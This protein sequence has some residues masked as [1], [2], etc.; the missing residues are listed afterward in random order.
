MRRRIT[1]LA[2][3]AV[4]GAAAAASAENWPMWGRTPDRNM[5]SH[6]KGIPAD[7]APGRFVQG[8]EKV[9]MTTTRHVKWVA[10]LG[11]QTHGN[12]TVAGGRVFVGTN[13]GSP[14]N[15]KMTGDRSIV[16]CFD[17]RTGELLWQL[18]VPKLGAGKVSDWEYLGICSSPAIDGERAYVVTTRGELV[19]LDVQGMAD[20][21]Q[22][23][24]DEATYATGGKGKLPIGEKDADIIWI[25]DVRSDL[26]VFP[27]NTSSNSPLVI[28]DV[29]Y[30][31]T[32]NGVDWSHK[33]LPSPAAPAMVG[34]NKKTGEL[35]GEEA[36]GISKRTLH[37]N[38]SS[39]AMGEIG[40]RMQLVFGGGDGW[41]Y[42]FDPKPVEDEDGFLIFPAL[43]RYNLNPPEYFQRDGRKIPYAHRLGP[44]EVI[45]TPVIHEGKVYIGTGQDPEHGNGVAN[46]A[47]ID[48]AGKKGDITE[49]GRVWEHRIGR[50][51]STASVV[52]DL[53]YVAEYAGYLNCLDAK[54][55]K[56]YWQHDLRSHIWSSTL[57]ADG[58][59]FV[60]DED[61]V[62]SIFAQGKEKKLINRVPFPSPIHTSP[63]VANGVLYIGSQT[64][65]YAIAVESKSDKTA[66]VESRK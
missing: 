45:A 42:G 53:V 19:C 9:D 3:L 48:P 58:K 63:I 14:R 33:N 52:G 51:M 57:A 27:H 26:D 28:G 66:A 6:E 56:L 41:V 47:C 29:V 44:S 21:N 62:L 5:V 18:A 64:H 17:E 31:G 38:W 4:I 43:W 20:G 40:G 34:V 50:T 15:P 49:S 1:L 8:A 39:P 25:Y 32:S 30:I 35:V 22:G 55:G 46:F 61:G 12:M 36:V 11:S 7:F 2:I 65:L 24:K 59:V 60:N 54:T 23:Y 16:M 37:C 10:K 13:N